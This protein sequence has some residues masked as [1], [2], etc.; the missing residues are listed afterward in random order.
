MRREGIEHRTCR[1]P[2][3]MCAVLKSLRTIREVS[4]KYF[5]HKNTYRYIDVLQKFVTAY[6]DALQSTTDVAPAKVI[7]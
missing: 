1:N 2:D 4:N 3:V 5:T 6:S 7:D